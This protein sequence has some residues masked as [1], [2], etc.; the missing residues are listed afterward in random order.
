MIFVVDSNDRG[1]V[2]DSEEKL[3]KMNEDEM[4]DAI[5][6]A[7]ADGL[8][9]AQEWR[10]LV[11][12]CWWCRRRQWCLN[13]AC[14]RCVRQYLNAYTR[15]SCGRARLEPHI[16]DWEVEMRSSEKWYFQ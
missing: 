13:A 10:S 12:V 16:P 7:F 5:V 8:T 9:R 3:N 14:G 4:R 11:V 2:E 1:R 15:M 6:L